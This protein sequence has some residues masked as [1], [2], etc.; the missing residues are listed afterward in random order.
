MVA[1]VTYTYV[2]LDVSEA[3][4]AE[5]RQKLE[6]AGYSHAFHRSDDE[7]EVIDMHGIALRSKPDV[8]RHAT[9]RN[10]HFDRPL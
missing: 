3:A 8:K 2:L 4:Y 1:P 7:P 10:T 6:E 9:A 5:I